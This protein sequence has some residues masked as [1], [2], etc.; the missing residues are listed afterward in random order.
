MNTLSVNKGEV[1]SPPVSR[2][3]QSARQV[4]MPLPHYG[5]PANNR[6]LSVMW[7]GGRM[8]AEAWVTAL[9]MADSRR[10]L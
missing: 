3:T 8:A 9:H 7:L 6:R 4:L 10:K 2:G 5:I 1:E